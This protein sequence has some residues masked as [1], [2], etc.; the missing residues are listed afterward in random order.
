MKKDVDA[1]DKPEHDEINWPSRGREGLF[2]CKVIA[3]TT[4]K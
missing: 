2:T 4:A 1:R 3:T